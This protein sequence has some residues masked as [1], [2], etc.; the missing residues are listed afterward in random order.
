MNLLKSELVEHKKILDAF[1][2]LP[3][4]IKKYILEFHCSSSA[5]LICPLC[6]EASYKVL[7]CEGG[8]FICDHN[9]Y[10]MNRWLAPP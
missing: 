9:Y 8:C 3:K 6:Y 7:I 1:R 10:K 2:L 5:I 4:D